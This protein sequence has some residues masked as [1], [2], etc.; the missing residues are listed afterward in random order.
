MWWAMR[1]Y[2]SVL[3]QH[4]RVEPGLHTCREIWL[5]GRGRKEKRRLDSYG[6][7]INDRSMLSAWLAR[8]WSVDGCL[9]E[10][11]SEFLHI[12]FAASCQHNCLQH[13]VQLLSRS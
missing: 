11:I 9:V 7:R 12:Q 5:L 13:M 2:L 3:V 10:S 1:S 8:G 6:R 4:V